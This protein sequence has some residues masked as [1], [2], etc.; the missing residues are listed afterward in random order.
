MVLDNEWALKVARGEARLLGM[1]DVALRLGVSRSTVER[2]TR[3]AKEA[4]ALMP[5][6]IF[7]KERAKNIFPPRDDEGAGFPAP[8]VHINKSPKWLES[9]IADWLIASSK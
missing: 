7:G 3:A 8:D 1:D 2:W 9:T 5:S 4:K 6:T